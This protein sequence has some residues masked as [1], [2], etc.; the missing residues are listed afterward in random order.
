MP[1]AA[2]LPKNL[3]IHTDARPRVRREKTVAELTPGSRQAFGRGC[4]CSVVTEHRSE[5][6]VVLS[7]NCPHHAGINFWHTKER[8]GWA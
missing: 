6:M 8:R 4:R 3:T 5:I 7:G 2:R 1:N